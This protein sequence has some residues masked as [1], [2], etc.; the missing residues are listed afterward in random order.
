MSVSPT[1]GRI[2]HYR[3]AERGV[4][5]AII[6]AVRGNGTDALGLFVFHDGGLTEWVN[7][8][9][10]AN[11]EEE[12]GW[13]WPT[14]V[15]NAFAPVTPTAP[16]PAEPT[17]PSPAPVVA[18]AAKAE[19]SDDKNAH[20]HKDGTDAPAPAPVVQVAPVEAPEASASVVGGGVVVHPHERPAHHNKSHKK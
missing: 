5:P 14:I 3:S 13:R 2:V 16:A 19:A 6:A 15:K 8:A 11:T 10:Q 7:A 18:E 9:P 20:E 17:V 12:I 4:A 1:I